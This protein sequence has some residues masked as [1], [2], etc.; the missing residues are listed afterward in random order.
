M[1]AG[2]AR[3]VAGRWRPLGL[4]LLLLLASGLAGCTGDDG[5]DGPVVESDADGDGIDTAEDACPSLP[6]NSTANGTI[7]CPDSDGDGWADR[8][9]AFDGE[10]TQWND[11]DGDGFGD[12]WADPALNVSRGAAGIGQWVHLAA[13]TDSC[14]EEAGQTTR[15]RPGC[16]DQDGDQYSDV[17]DA[18]PL[19]A[20][21]HADADGDGYGDDRE[22]TTPDACPETPGTSTALARYGCP[23]SDGDGWDDVV[24][25]FPED[26]DL[27]RDSDG[28]GV[29]DAIDG[30][31]LDVTQ[32]HDKDFDGYGDNAS[33]NASDACPDVRGTSTEDRLGCLD[34][35]GDGWSNDG[36][37]LPNDATQHLD[38]DG[39]GFGDDPNGTLPDACPQAS[40]NSTANDTWGCPDTDGDG[41]ADQEDLWPTDDE[42]WELGQGTVNVVSV[43][44][45]AGAAT[46]G[47]NDSLVQLT[48]SSAADDLVWGQ[49]EV[50]L[51]VD[52]RTWVCR[53]GATSGCAI[54]QT[55][56]DATTWG[57]S[58]VIVLREVDAAISGQD[59]QTGTTATITIRYQ[60]YAV[61]PS[62]LSVE[63]A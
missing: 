30:F 22:G 23:D 3:S 31:P 5:A 32:W 39:D 50:I 46:N 13:F 1:E 34:D 19:D 4:V 2:W 40:G 29:D 17:G 10:P 59:D 24:D 55:D 35:D 16:P 27:A 9:D 36:D 48:W 33:G 7:G 57:A 14:P 38:T 63:V 18:F 15:D 21:Q 61:E 62:P 11:T 45:H 49:V 12:N 44:D 58:D 28:D 6:G 56:G 53:V 47:T 41:W 26:P 60:G 43:A 20:T 51:E 8:I 37:A 54:E 42:R 52:G 25:D